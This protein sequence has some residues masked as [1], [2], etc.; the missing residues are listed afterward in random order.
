MMSRR[1]AE[2]LNEGR[3]EGVQAV[4]ELRFTVRG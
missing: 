4:V 3:P 1:L 2:G